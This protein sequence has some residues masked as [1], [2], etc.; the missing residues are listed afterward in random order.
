MKKKKVWKVLLSFKFRKNGY[1]TIDVLKINIAG[2][3]FFFSIKN[4]C[5]TKQKLNAE[6]ILLCEMGECVVTRLR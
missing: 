4:S 3:M 2:Y 6:Q 5:K 1:F